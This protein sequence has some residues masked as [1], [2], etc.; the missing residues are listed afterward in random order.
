M[1]GSVL[2]GN[3]HLEASSVPSSN[4]TSV[5]HV[6]QNVL[7]E[8][9]LAPHRRGELAADFFDGSPEY[10]RTVEARLFKSVASELMSLC[11]QN[12]RETLD[13]GTKPRILLAWDHGHAATRAVPLT[14]IRGS[15]SC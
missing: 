9:P 6:V 11:F 13:L 2:S 8:L 7:H 10:R 12:L 1:P 3:Q 4:E 14:P 5:L 15:K